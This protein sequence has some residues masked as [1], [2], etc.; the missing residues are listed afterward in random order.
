MCPHG[1]RKSCDITTSSRP[2]Q[3][4]SY[5][6][7]L[8]RL[9][10]AEQTSKSLTVLPGEFWT[11]ALQMRPCSDRRRVSSP[12][13]RSSSRTLGRVNH[14]ATNRTP[15]RTQPARRAGEGPSAAR[16]RRGRRRERSDTGRH[17]P[18]KVER[19]TPPGEPDGGRTPQA[20]YHSMYAQARRGRRV[21][22][23]PASCCEA[24]ASRRGGRPGVPVG[25]RSGL[26]GRVR[27]PAVRTAPP[28]SHDTVTVS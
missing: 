3:G 2:G 6:E 10:T 18:G 21:R 22:E 11:R 26:A 7:A 14:A 13:F 5:G 12:L 4:R 20:G 15:A 28:G 19:E 9:E 8:E 1:V 24:V 17:H 25:A 16:W 27:A 23:T